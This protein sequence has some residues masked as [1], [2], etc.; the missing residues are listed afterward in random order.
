M[1]SLLTTITIAAHALLLSPSAE[2]AKD[3]LSCLAKNAFY[4]ARNQG[5]IGMAAVI[6]VTL[7]R[8][9]SS[10]YPNSV[11]GVVF[12]K[13]QFS[14]THEK[15]QKVSNK[16]L[17]VALNKAYEIA[18]RKLRNHQHGIR[19][20]VVGDSL[21]YYSDSIKTPYWAR[22]GKL[23]KLKKINNHTFFVVNN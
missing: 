18:E 13:Y 19:K 6:D 3:D 9:E 4:E 15:P 16:E 20:S 1:K 10:R 21:W 23:R 12:Q 22:N 2:A 7:N 14:W 8:V 11:C 17:E 5:D